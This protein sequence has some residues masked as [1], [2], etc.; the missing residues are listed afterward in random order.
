M[1]ALISTL[2]AFSDAIATALEPFF[3]TITYAVE[4]DLDPAAFIDVL[5][6]STLGERRPV[7]KPD[8]VARMV[9]GAQLI[10]T[11]RDEAARDGTA[12]G[13]LVGVARS[14]TDFAY[15]CYLSDLAV[16][17]AYQRGG[18]G[19]ELMR[20]TRAACGPECTLILLSAPKAMSYYPHVGM[21]RL[22]NAFAFDRT[23]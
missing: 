22:E 4:P 6:R 20:R 3:L 18:I 21:R 11:A 13:R 2:I 1:G 8:Q 7:D 23:Q 15:C 14:I 17:E 9:R 5:R 19:R 10:V 16:D 12:A